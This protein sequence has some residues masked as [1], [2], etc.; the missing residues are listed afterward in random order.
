MNIPE[1][2]NLPT[3]CGERVR[4]RPPVERDKEDRLADGRDP[5]FRRMVGGDPADCSPLTMPE[6]ERW[7]EQ[8]CRAPLHWVIEAEGRSIGVAR[9]LAPDRTNRR[10]RYAVG[11]F[12]PEFR[13]RGY[14]TEATRLVLRCAFEGLGFHRT[15]A[16]R[17]RFQRPR[18][19]L[20]PEVRLR[21]GGARARQCVNRRRM[22]G[23]MC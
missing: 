18:H 17:P 8:L 7:Y 13:G 9:L 10:A 14:G 11:I 20:L 2:Q 5:E 12:S 16:A 23:A 4:L 1:P 22:A 21:R 19:R 3:L 6:V 15:R